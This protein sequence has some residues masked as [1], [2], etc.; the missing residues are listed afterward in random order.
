MTALTTSQVRHALQP[1]F[2]GHHKYLVRK[3][4]L[5]QNRSELFKRL[6]A[7]KFDKLWPL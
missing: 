7:F 5:Q 4:D 2:V 3:Q 6:L 1:L